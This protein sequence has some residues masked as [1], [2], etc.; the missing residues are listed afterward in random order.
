MQKL[1]KRERQIR[2]SSLLIVPGLSFFYIV[3]S[4]SNTTSSYPDLFSCEIKRS[5]VLQSK[6][7]KISLSFY[8]RSNHKPSLDI[9]IEAFDSL[10]K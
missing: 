5:E 8:E 2:K 7:T 9:G 4:P 3:Y 6:I 10:N 1:I